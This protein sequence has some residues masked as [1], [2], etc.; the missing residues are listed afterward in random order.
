[1]PGG[2]KPNDLIRMMLSM[3]PMQRTRSYR[4][5]AVP[6]KRQRSAQQN[7]SL[8]KKWSRRKRKTKVAGIT[9]EASLLMSK[10]RTHSITDLAF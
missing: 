9:V 1:L 2:T 3:W 8:V 5:A 10:G 6:P 4:P 7:L